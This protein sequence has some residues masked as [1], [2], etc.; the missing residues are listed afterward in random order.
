MSCEIGHD[1]PISWR[2]ID[3]FWQSD[4]D[5][6]NMGSNA[7]QIVI[8]NGLPVAAKFNKKTSDSKRTTLDNIKQ[9][10]GA[11]WNDNAVLILKQASIYIK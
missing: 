6:N 4:P 9:H 2:Q 8:R 3:S 7:V 1:L 10:F 5:K 11:G